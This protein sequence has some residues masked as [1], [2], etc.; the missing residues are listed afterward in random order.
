MKNL[1]TLLKG[2]GAKPLVAPGKGALSE[3][4][5]T[6]TS[7]STTNPY[8]EAR[9]E[10]NERYGDYISQARN[11]RYLAYI[12]AVM[13]F[14]AVMW[15]GYIGSQNKIVPYVVQVDKFGAAVAVGPGDKAQPVD[16][17]VIKAFLARFINDWRT[18]TTDRVQQKEAVVRVYAM[19]PVGSNAHKKMNDYYQE[20]NPFVRLQQGT[21]TVEPTSLLPISEKTW[22]IEWN[23]VSRNLKGEASPQ[24]RFKASLIL[25]I[26]PPTDEHEVVLNPLG[27]FVTDFNLA[28]QL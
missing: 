16:T 24:V 4:N 19:L 7:T 22:Q 10:W 25:A 17:K 18:V 28:Q 20:N 1:M 13:A 11:W 2:S 23:E 27:V 14:V 15:V 9:R 26:T 3:K 6:E 8:V 5:A 12:S 21:V